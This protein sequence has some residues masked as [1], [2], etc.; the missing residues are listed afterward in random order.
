MAET[1]IEKGNYLSALSFKV[2]DL[3]SDAVLIYNETGL[4]YFNKVANDLFMNDIE[5]LHTNLPFA[6]KLD[7]DAIHFPLKNW[8]EQWKSLQSRKTAGVSNQTFSFPLTN[9]LSADVVAKVEC[10]DNQDFCV[11]ILRNI[12]R[13]EIDEVTAFSFAEF[14]RLKH[15]EKTLQESERCYRTVAEL[16]GSLI[17]NLDLVANKLTWQGPIEQ[18]TG[19]THDEFEEFGIE[20]HIASIHPDDRERVTQIFKD[21]L[22]NRTAIK[23]EFKYQ[24]KNGDYIDV[25]E[26]GIV[27]YDDRHEPIRVIGRKKD[28]T[29]RKQAELQLMESEKWYR[30]LFEMA[31]DAIFVIEDKIVV[32]CNSKAVSV[33]GRDR[34]EL[35]GHYGLT[36]SCEFQAD[37]VSSYERILQILERVEDGESCFYEWQFH[38]TDGSIFFAE[39]SVSMIQLLSRKLILAIVRDV[40]VRKT[41]EQALVVSEKRFRNLFNTMFNG[42][43]VMLPIFDEVGKMVDARYVDVNPY[44]LKHID[45]R[46]DEVV[47]RT[48][49]D[50]VGNKVRWLDKYEHVFR[51][52]QSIDFQDYHPHFN[53]YFKMKI[54]KPSEEYFAVMIEDITQQVLAENVLHENELKYQML[55]N[56]MHSACTINLPYFDET[57]KLVDFEYVEVNKAFEAQTGVA[58]ERVQGKRI[59]QLLK[60]YDTSWYD[61]FSL[62]INTGQSI[63]SEKYSV[64]LNRHFKVNVFKQSDHFFTTI[65]DDITDLKNA[66]QQIVDTIV[67]VE[68]RERRQL[69]CDLH[70]EIGPQ[71][72]SMRMYLATLLRLGLNDSQKEIHQTVIELLDQTITSVRGISANLSPA[73]LERFGLAAAI[74]AECDYARMLFHVDFKSNIQTCRF[75]RKVELMIYRIVKELL[76]NTKKYADATLATLSVTAGNGTLSLIYTDNGK[77]FCYESVMSAPHTG[78]G[79]T[80]IEM[81]VKSLNG[82]SGFKTNPLGQGV[83]FEL[84]VPIISCQTLT[85]QVN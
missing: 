48:M 16:S 27:F 60:D 5:L 44:F 58:V 82:I 8:G 65:F 64:E 66:E 32:D 50:L 61:L 42:L 13:D 75:N 26:F 9:K 68:E 25:D 34:S 81:R 6:F 1:T 62:A 45:K 77:G 15:I 70:D 17:Y 59:S 37:G 51:T 41:I 18:I 40:S 56:N 24:I 54:F 69:A 83:Y 3:I 80:N 30:N 39:V 36:Y 57:G 23:S 22:Q 28:I 55:F 2:F 14:E 38:R 52:G 43:I 53:G 20:G 46:R 74:N 73:L 11:F 63:S 29:A 19:Y 10:I 76:N 33:F 7:V 35:V 85:E 49:V 12:V 79:L 21:A 84:S 47:G 4:C 71:L 78:M 72:V 67:E 31:N